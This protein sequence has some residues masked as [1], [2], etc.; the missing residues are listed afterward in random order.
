MF[1]C[2]L[3]HLFNYFL[4]RYCST[5]KHNNL[6][7]AKPESLEHSNKPNCEFFKLF[8]VLETHVTRIEL[9]KFIA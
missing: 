9:I 3:S 4:K 5:T 2:D 6:P 7:W 1:L 8:P